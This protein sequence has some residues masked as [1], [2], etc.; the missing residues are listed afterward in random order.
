MSGLLALP[1]FD[2]LRGLSIDLLTRLAWTTLGQRHDPLQSPVVVVALDEETYVSKPFAGTPSVT[3]TREIGRV[4]NAIIDGGAKVVGFD[5]VFPNTI[6]QSEIPFGTETIGARMRGFDRDFLRALA[7]AARDG[8]LVLGE[9][10]GEVRPIT[11]SDAQRL[12]VSHQRNIRPLNLYTDADGVVRRVPLTMS[13]EGARTPSMSLELASRVLGIAADIDSK[14]EVELGAYRVPSRIPDTLTL[15]FQGGSDDIPTYSLA[16]LRE[17]VDRGDAAYFRRHF[18]GRAVLIGVLLDLEDRSLTSKRF[19]TG[20]EG[21]RAPRC[22]AQPSPSGKRFVR[23][24]IAGV[25]V[26]ATAASNLLRRDAL[27]EVGRFP[28]WVL[29]FGFATIAG[30]AV[31]VLSLPKAALFFSSF[32]LLWLSIAMFAFARTL[33]LPLVD[34]G[35]VAVLAI[36]ATIAYRFVVTDKDK[37][38]LRRSFAFYL[39]PTL[40][41]KMMA[42]NK[43]PSLGGETRIVTLYRSDIAGFTSFSEKLTAEDLVAL[44]NAYLTA[45]TDIIDEHGGFVDK[46]IGDAI[47]GVFGAPLDDEHHAL[48]AVRAALACQARLRDMNESGLDKFKGHKLRQRIGLHT[49][50]AL[51]GNI[52]SRQRFNYTVMGDAANLASRLEGANKVYGTSIIASEATVQLAGSAITYREL[53][54]IR[55]V[56]RDEPVRI[57]EP[58]AERGQETP[59]QSTCAISYAEGLARWRLRD[60]RGAAE[61]FGPFADRDLPSCL[62]RDR[63]IQLMRV[64]PEV[65]WHPVNNLDSK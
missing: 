37:R 7:N 26:H 42:S 9:V 47:D 64:P 57:F 49:G 20:I 40:I 6:E 38:L 39:A 61:I 59:L 36:S 18:S 62:F 46:Y 31:L 51:V 21:A 15:N 4:L 12:A 19:A 60:F 17:C 55:V 58:I 16:D 45:M 43:P 1:Q 34:A 23:D 52:G 3:W 13:I 54:T 28:H 5:I 41:D 35:A 32:L 48:N 27:Q 11:P 63:A 10:R 8:K 2:W 33:V 22:A 29:S 65:D 30:V 50:S 24:T 53:D 56:G 25:Y 44:M 14:R